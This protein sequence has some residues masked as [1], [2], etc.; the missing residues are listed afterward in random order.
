MAR[1]Q[2]LLGAAVVLLILAAHLAGL[3]EG[4]ELR[5]ID[6]RTG[7]FRAQDAP[8]RDDIAVLLI[9]DQTLETHGR[10]PWPRSMLATLF[11]ELADA[12]ASVVACDVMFSNSQ[13]AEL[14]RGPGGDVFEVDH[15]RALSESI[16][17]HGRSVLATSFAFN[18]STLGQRTVQGRDLSDR[19][20]FEAVLEQLVADP[21]RSVASLREI[22]LPGAAARGRHADALANTRQAAITLIDARPTSSRPAGIAPARWPL[23]NEPTPPVPAIA[24]SAAMLASVSSGGEDDA[25][26]GVRRMPLWFRVGDW[27]YPTLGLGAAALHRGV[28]IDS[29][30]VTPAATSWPESGGAPLRTARARLT[31]FRELGPVD[32]ATLLNWP[33]GVP[34]VGWRARLASS[35][36]T[37]GSPECILPVGRVLDPVYT[38]EPAIR[39]SLAFIDANVLAAGPLLLGPD[40]VEAYT[41]RAERLQDPATPRAERAADLEAQRAVWDELLEAIGFALGDVDVDALDEAEATEARALLALRGVVPEQVA[42]IDEG[43]ERIRRWRSEEL[44][45]IVGGKVCFIG[46]DSTGALA[47]FVS[48]SVDGQT[49][50]VIVHAVV[51][52]NALAAADGARQRALGPRWADA[53][54]VLGVGLIAVAIGV[55]LDV[56]LSPF[57]LVLSLAG[58]FMFDGLA[59]WGAGR[60]AVASATPAL[61][62]F[63]AWLAIILHRLFVEQRGRQRTEARFRSYVPPDVVDIL[64]NNPALDSMAPQKRELTI[65]FSDIAGFT[66]LSERLGTEGTSALL[67]TYLGAMTDALQSRRATLD[68]YLGDGIMAFWGAPIDDPQHARNAAL[69]TLD[70]LERLDTMNARGDFNGPGGPERLVVRVGLAAGE[71]NVGDFGNPPSKSAYTV[72]GDAVNLAARLESANKQFGTTVLANG[73]AVEL[74]GGGIPV[75][76]VGRVVVKGKTQYETLFEVIGDRLPHA[77]RTKEWISRTEEAV[78]AYQNGDFEAS[79]RLWA[80]LEAEFGDSALAEVYRHSIGLAIAG[81]QPFEGTVVLTEK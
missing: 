33:S 74:M 79:H 53:L 8:F 50:G 9:D 69:A 1:I 68:K 11:D 19:A 35:V 39:R 24:R 73:R 26:L 12:G 23:S 76:P 54:V 66:T 13:A 60:V 20:T 29:F 52:N 38:I 61:A 47:D 5:A 62:G 64:V 75:R 57:V 43:V 77:E 55:R 10:W 7:V 56:T 45:A 3:T 37:A 65:M 41:A 46:W 40:V 6:L 15:D 4:M 16:A 28:T 81:G 71:V 36:E 78:R 32:G 31:G 22:L 63:A 59:V 72:I 58:W 44:P 70:M 67:A 27:L 51:A 17:R 25:A 14:V 42:S 21:E 49:P 48:T 2:A 34:G 30:A 18:P 80:T